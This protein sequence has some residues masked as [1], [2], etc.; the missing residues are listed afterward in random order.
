VNLFSSQRLLLGIVLGIVL[1]Y[2]VLPPN[3]EKIKFENFALGKE[4]TVVLGH[5]DGAKVHCHDLEDFDQCL[6]GYKRRGFELPVT[7]WLGNSQVHAIN[8][9]SVGEETAVP[10]L[11]RRFQEQDQ[12]FLTL[13][14]PNA[15]LQEHLLLFSY[16]LK[17]IP[18][19][20]LVLP[21]VFDDM[22]EDGIRT[23]LAA[24]LKDQNTSEILRTTSIGK[25]LIANHG[26]QD[27]AGNDMAALE[28][29]VQERSEKWLNG[30]LEKIWPLWAK[31]PTLRGNFLSSL[32]LLR[33]WALGI[34]PTSTRKMIPGRYAKNRDAFEA[35][36]DLAGKVGINVLV[37]VVPLRN[38]VKVPYDPDEYVFFKAEI[39]T[40]AGRGNV[41]FVNLEGLVPSELWGSKAATTLG[42]RRQELD[43]M[44]FQAGGHRLL[45]EVLYQELNKLWEPGAKR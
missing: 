29:T 20:T 16:L 39:S 1:L 3:K 14:Q 4:S 33:N 17:Q 11:H 7:L 6:A 13:S 44:H 45:A 25:S 21:V 38:D 36:L 41:R 30:V 37:Y 10:R 12:Y 26:D 34:D 8:Q 35:I 42:G 18:I 43:F 19:N 31:R 5:V 9:Y 28:D 24:A 32:Y 22:R 23:S 15:S 2:Q 40:M 27:A